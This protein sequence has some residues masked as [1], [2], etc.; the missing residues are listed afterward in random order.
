MTYHGSKKRYLNGIRGA[1]PV[2]SE[3]YKE[4][5]KRRNEAIAQLSKLKLWSSTDLLPSDDESLPNWAKSVN[6]SQLTVIVGETRNRLQRA[7]TGPGAPCLSAAATS[8][9]V[10]AIDC[11]LG[12]LG[13]IAAA[14]KGGT[15]DMSQGRPRC[16]VDEWLGWEGERLRESNL[17]VVGTPEVNLVALFLHGLVTEFYYGEKWPPNL[18]I[19]GDWIS[20]GQ[21]QVRR[22]EGGVTRELDVGSVILLKNP[23]NPE[24][25][26]LWVCGMTGIATTAAGGLVANGWNV[27]SKQSPRWLSTAIGVV[28]ETTKETIH[29]P[30]P[31]GYLTIDGSG[32][33]W[34]PISQ[35]EEARS[36]IFISYSHS[37][38]GTMKTLEGFL[39][40]EAD[41]HG[42]QVRSDN[43]VKCGEDWSRTI[44]QA[45][46]RAKVAV[47][48]VSPNYLRSEFVS[49]VELPLILKAQSTGLTIAWIPVKSTK[50]IKS[51]I[52]RIQA[53]L[54]LK[55][56][57]D[58]MNQAEKEAALKVIAKKVV[59]LALEP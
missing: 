43:C 29:S 8:D 24:F 51:E 7:Q 49:S 48:L 13:Q 5:E 37:D 6:S 21:E 58:R 54:P 28:F 33:V 26:V 31:K 56:P 12:L 34:R 14:S 11:T 53:L 27:H 16:I 20:W 10:A 39:K 40:K 57:L 3:P 45:I 4:H 36:G 19:T 52:H 2:A 9:G 38:D 22:T 32:P 35:T 42:V 17:V 46:S 50:S 47:I 41:P 18:A 1:L 23:W 44:I 30:V 15:L 25:R 59:K 55:L